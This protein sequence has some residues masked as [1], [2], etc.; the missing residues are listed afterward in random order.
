[1]RATCAP[2]ARH[3]SAPPP[4]SSRRAAPTHPF[5][6]PPAPPPSRPTAAARLAES[7][8]AAA[9]SERSLA[10]M[11]A[12]TGLRVEPRGDAGGCGAGALEGFY[13]CSTVVPESGEGA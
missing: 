2:R 5:L 11:R 1:M 8:R 10:F 7:E 12:L 4:P 6:A 13:T 9:A 3:A